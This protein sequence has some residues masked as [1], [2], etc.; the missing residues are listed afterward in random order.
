MGNSIRIP[1]TNKPTYNSLIEK[2]ANCN[3]GDQL[4]S[5]TF[6]KWLKKSSFF[7][8]GSNVDYTTPRIDF[9]SNGLLIKPDLLDGRYLHIELETESSF[10]VVDKNVEKE[11]TINIPSGGASSQVS[12]RHKLGLWSKRRYFP[13][14]FILQNNHK[15]GLTV[16]GCRRNLVIAQSLDRKECQIPEFFL[17]DIEKCV[18]LEKFSH[19]DIDDMAWHECYISPDLTR[20]VLRPESSTP[21]PWDQVT[22]GSERRYNAGSHEIIFLKKFQ[23]PFRNI[24]TFDNRHPNQFFF[25]AREKDLYLLDLNTMETVSSVKGIAV[26]APIRQLKSSPSG[27]FLALRCVYP[28][29]SMEYQINKVAI[30]RTADMSLLF[31]V[32][33][34]GPYWPVSEVVNLQV[35]PRFSLCDSAFAV[36]RNYSSKRKVYLHKLPVMCFTLQHFCRRVILRNTSQDDINKLPLPKKVISYLNYIY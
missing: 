27:E 15:G 25:R 16:I 24:L 23:D 19:K 5:C 4:Y 11:Y 10:R 1:D 6:E 36:M 3:P 33:A 34:K 2:L 20:I 26:P 13:I 35:F 32:D 8:F 18:F 9:L 30:V 17:L 14:H 29:L 22:Q 12:L 31:I 7:G 21:M 28:V